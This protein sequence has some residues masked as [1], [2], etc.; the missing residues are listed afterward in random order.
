MQLK[1]S[2]LLYD[3]ETPKPGDKAYHSQQLVTL[4]KKNYIKLKGIWF[5]IDFL[6]LDKGSGNS[7]LLDE[8]GSATVA[9]VTLKKFESIMMCSR[10]EYQ[11]NLACH[12]QIK[13][14][15]F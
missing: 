10:C 14:E 8:K 15:Q 11:S 13:V 1:L 12:E 2:N 9:N 4:A 5:F 7:R 3:L 6:I